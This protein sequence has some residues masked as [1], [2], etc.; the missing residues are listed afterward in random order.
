MEVFMFDHVK[1]FHQPRTV[2]KAVT[3]LQQKG[4]ACLVAG[5]TDLVLRAGR[6]VTDLVD[7]TRLGLDY[8][9]GGVKGMRIGAATTLAAIEHSSEVQRL[10]N[11]ILAKAAAACGTVQ[12]RN[13]A[14][15]G[16]NLANAS[17]AA[18]TATPLLVLDAAV[19]LQ[20]SRAKRQVALVDFFRAPHETAA[21]GSLLTEIVLPAC[22]AN[23][24]WSFQRFGRTEL[25]I[26]IVNA[27]TGLQLD[28]NGRCTWARIALGAVAPIPV[29]ARKAESLITGKALDAQLLEQAAEAALE[30]IRP[31]TD[32][33]A[34][35]EYRREI[36][37]VLV[38][39]ALQE[40]A[41]HL[42]CEL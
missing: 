6:S 34:S 20:G 35:A 15:I 1:A 11:G 17:P 21:K 28:R 5:G 39:R 27:A 10:A 24:A 4:K 8:I 40:C 7:I 2:Q 23:A 26:A 12:M 33:R 13:V 41:Q 22:K 3:L 29:R 36:S 19:V 32:V 16:G 18:D 14:T 25:D 9:K 31:I 30:D 38:R 42:E 37:R